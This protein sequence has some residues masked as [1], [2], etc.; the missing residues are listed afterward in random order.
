MAPRFTIVSV[1]G[2]GLEMLKE[3]RLVKILVQD[4]TN[5]RANKYP[6]SEEKD[7]ELSCELLRDSVDILLS[8]LTRRQS[9]V[10]WDVIHRTYR[11]GEYDGRSTV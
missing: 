8:K 10:L 5:N 1:A 3:K 9:D 6:V 2:K 11:I 7:R 4:V